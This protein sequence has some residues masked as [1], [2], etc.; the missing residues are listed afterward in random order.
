MRR[1]VLCCRK[2]ELRR[3]AY[4]P[5]FCVQNTLPPLTLPI[6]IPGTNINMKNGLSCVESLEDSVESG[7]RWLSN[8][9]LEIPPVGSHRRVLSVVTVR[10]APLFFRPP[11]KYDGLGPYR[12]YNRFQKMKFGQSV[13][14]GWAGQSSSNQ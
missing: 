2:M 7:R 6:L 11:V 3:R 5:F 12:W 4:Q 8:F 14:P 9:V 10:I 1:S 13:A